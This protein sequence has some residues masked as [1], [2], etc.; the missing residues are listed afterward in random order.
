MVTEPFDNGLAALD[1]ESLLQEHQE[2]RER[3]RHLGP[4]H[5]S[6]AL[7]GLMWAL[8]IYVILMIA[9]VVVNVFQ[10]IG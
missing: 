3:I 1:V 8:R 4:R 10:N 2:S 9:T 7:K 6:P 5:L